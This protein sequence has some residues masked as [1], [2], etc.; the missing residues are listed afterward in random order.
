MKTI[1]RF[2]L[3]TMLLAAAG[4]ATAQSWTYLGT[5]KGGV[6]RVVGETAQGIVTLEEKD[7]KATVRIVGGPE[8]LCL[9]GEMPARVTRTEATTTIEPTFPL[10][11]CEPF[12]LV[13]RNDGSGGERQ[14]KRG[15]SW[16]SGKTDP[17]LKPVK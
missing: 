5:R 7:G 2:A 10:P 3:G 4:L 13:I 16:V 9:R 1:P 6:S 8:S 14:V 17:G 11:D 15:E 12:R